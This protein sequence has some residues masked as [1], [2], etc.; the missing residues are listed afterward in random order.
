MMTIFSRVPTV[1][2]PS[3]GYPPAALRTPGEGAGR[4]EAV[5]PHSRLPTGKLAAAAAAQSRGQ[6]G[7]SPLLLSPWTRMLL[8]GQLPAGQR[9]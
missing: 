2:S 3:P 5:D 6:T 7:A 8:F 1:R 9:R 4:S